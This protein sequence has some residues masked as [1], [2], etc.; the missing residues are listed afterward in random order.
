MNRRC[1]AT[2]KTIYETIG[3]AKEAMIRFKSMP[4]HYVVPG[5][6]VKHR[7]RKPEQKRTYY[8]QNC[9]G[10]HLTKWET[11]KKNEFSNG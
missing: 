4:D 11:Y 3:K 9:E 5:K 10:F 2:G 8:C 1:E 6:R 7:G